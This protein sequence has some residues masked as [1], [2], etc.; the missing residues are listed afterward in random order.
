MNM[1]EAAMADME[2]YE[3]IAAELKCDTL[4]ETQ[5]QDMHV[6]ITMLLAMTHERKKPLLPISRLDKAANAWQKAK[7]LGYDMDN[8][9][10]TEYFEALHDALRKQQALVKKKY[11]EKLAACNRQSAKKILQKPLWGLI[12]LGTGV[13]ALTFYIPVAVM[14]ICSGFALILTIC[15]GDNKQ[16]V[17]DY[18]LK[19]AKSECESWGVT[20]E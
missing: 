1:L 9:V 5:A 19:R 10:W 3:Y 14:L 7:D 20:I 13:Y 15:H 6:W 12:L 16:N 2:N 4:A 8:D 18:E 17:M 11:D